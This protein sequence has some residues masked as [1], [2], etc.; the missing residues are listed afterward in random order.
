MIIR[1]RR[2]QSLGMTQERTLVNQQED[3]TRSTNR[4]GP[5]DRS[6]PGSRSG[7]SGNAAHRVRLGTAA[8]GAYQRSTVAS[9]RAPR[10]LAS[11]F[12]VKGTSSQT[13][14]GSLTGDVVA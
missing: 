10:A 11:S 4:P 1:R 2:S 6:S 14:A 3:G 5:K 12:S 7:M 9:Q 13:R 8:G